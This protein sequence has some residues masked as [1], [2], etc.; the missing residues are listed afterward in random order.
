MK[1]LI[2]KNAVR[3]ELPNH[4]KIHDVVN[5]MHTVP[6]FS[7]PSEI[8]AP[9]IQR[10]DPVPTAEGKEYVVD[11]ILRHRRRGRGYQ[12]LTLMK[13]DPTHEAE[14]Q[15]MRDFIDKDGTMNAKFLEYIKKQNILPNLYAYNE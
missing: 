14:W 5:V 12:F 15:P 3:L 4:V 9:V 2:G 8:S 7:Q 11:K 10:P 1:E 6:H 13:G